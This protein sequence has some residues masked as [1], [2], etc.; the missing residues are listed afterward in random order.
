MNFKLLAFVYLSQIHQCAAALHKEWRDTFAQT[1]KEATPPHRWKPVKNSG[2]IQA[3][4]TWK[5]INPQFL[6]LVRQVDKGPDCP[7][8]IEID[9]FNLPYEHLS[10]DWQEDNFKAAESARLHILNLLQTQ[11][12][13][14]VGEDAFVNQVADK[15]HQD[16]LSRREPSELT[17]WAKALNKPFAEL[18]KNEQDKDRAIVTICIRTLGL[19]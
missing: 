15:V 13:A 12:D 2:W 14:E 6:N 5:V 3:L 19:S 8:D 7:P 11:P 17:G 10:P 16:W 9:I 4:D 1:W 18:P